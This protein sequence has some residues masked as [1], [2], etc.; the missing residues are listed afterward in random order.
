[1]RMLFIFIIRKK[2]LESMHVEATQSASEFSDSRGAA[3]R[4]SICVDEI[5][6]HISLFSS[7]EGNFCDFWVTYFINNPVML[8]FSIYLVSL[9]FPFYY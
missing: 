4:I 7:I 3:D 6:R 8:L 9:L 5:H 1:M 2:D